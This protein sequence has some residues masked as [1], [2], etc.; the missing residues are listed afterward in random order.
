MSWTT[1]KRLNKFHII[2]FTL[3]LFAWGRLTL[4][5]ALYLE[6]K[7]EIVQPNKQ[8]MTKYFTSILIFKY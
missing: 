3:L 1:W 5:L 4:L 6:N 8:N 7:F 2:I